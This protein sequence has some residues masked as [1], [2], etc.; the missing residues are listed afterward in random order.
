MA[1]ENDHYRALKT[2]FSTLEMA[3]QYVDLARTFRSMKY[4]DEVNFSGQGR[5]HDRLVTA[6]LKQSMKDEVL[7]FA[8][9]KCEDLA[10]KLFQHEEP[11]F[12]IRKACN[13]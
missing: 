8:A 6:A 11:N 3:R 12:D 4:A 10:A 5:I 7:E 9:S 13:E 2:R 1:Y